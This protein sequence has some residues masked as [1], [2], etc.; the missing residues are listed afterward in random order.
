MSEKHVD[1]DAIDVVTSWVH[2]F[3]G[4]EEDTADNHHSGRLAMAVT[5]N[6]TASLMC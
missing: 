2:Y 4:S 1:E 5:T 3:K 6:T